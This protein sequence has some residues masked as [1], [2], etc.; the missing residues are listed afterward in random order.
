MY[1][2]NDP[3][4]KYDEKKSLD[5]NN[6]AFLVCITF[7][8]LKGSGKKKCFHLLACLYEICKKMLN[9]N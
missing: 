5:T 6:L 3:L 7:L 1:K 8:V 4:F 2:V 9:K